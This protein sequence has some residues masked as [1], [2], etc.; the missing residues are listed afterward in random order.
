M[1][2]YGTYLKELWRN[3]KSGITRFLLK[4]TTVTGI[5]YIT[6]EGTIMNYPEG[7]PLLV[8][9]RYENIKEKSVFVGRA[10]AYSNSE[11][12]SIKFLMSSN[13]QDIGEVLAKKIVEIIGC[14]IFDNLTEEKIAEISKI[15]G[16]TMKKA[17]YVS[18]KL[19]KY[20]D[21]EMLLHYIN[22]EGGNF[23][24]V[25]K[26]YDKYGS[27]ALEVIKKNPYILLY[28]DASYTLCEQ[29]AYKLGI[30]EYDKKRIEAIVR[31]SIINNEKN[32]NT[33][34]SFTAL[35]KKVKFY[36]KRAGM[37]YKTNPLF[38][39]E[40]I[41]SD[42]YHIEE[43]D[44]EIHVA[45]EKTNISEDIIVS[46]I[47][48]LIGVSSIY[49]EERQYNLERIQ[50]KNGIIYNSEQREVI[51]N[52]TE[53][54][55]ICIITGGPGTG[56]T[57]ILKAIIDVFEEE[58]ENSQIL[59]CSPT[60]QAAQ[61]MR[62]AT[63][64]QANT[65]HKTLNMKPYEDIL[66]VSREKLNADVIIVDEFS[67]VDTELFSI[68]LTRIKNGSLLI[69]MGDEQQLQSVGP[70]NILGDLIKSGK[71]PV[72]K[73]KTICR[74]S[75]GDENIIV[76]NAT[77]VIEGN[78]DLKQSDKFK[79]KILK[80]EGLVI[81]EL[82][83]LLE[84]K[85]LSGEFEDTKIYTPIRHK[86][87]NLGSVQLN[88]KIKERFFKTEKGV[89]SGQYFFSEGDF[90]IFNKNNY[91]KGY[92]NG[93]EGEIISIQKHTETLHICIQMDGD[94]IDI[95]KSEL[96]DIELGYA[97]TAH[98][99]QGSECKTS[100]IIVPE[101]PS[102]MLQRK[103]LYVEITRAKEEVYILSQNDA[104]KKAISTLYEAKRVTGLRNKLIAL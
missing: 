84:E 69:L 7:I 68:L 52:S 5:K 11:E 88:K 49:N 40:E 23:L 32:G 39:A 70:G 42:K 46:E 102:S 89:Y 24:N 83:S 4:Q 50:E 56:K 96:G 35:C 75:G 86:K 101:R 64:K 13:F 48:R 31:H 97:A 73:L 8:D 1:K 45:F 55:G 25:T 104:L 33:I 58:H 99:A 71:I 91:E 2:I 85:M 93:A 38:V 47:R 6:C 61:K 62:D 98:K 103:I 18:R 82:N 54:S 30:K 57:T 3:E 12:Y 26:V 44:N 28:A 22:E 27:D 100:I 15:N 10:M 74:Q 20:R 80:T 16:F 19:K 90:V 87:F 60:G 95:G 72:Y 78:Q 65:I 66:S 14:N 43:Y 17:E 34:I 76:E 53:R 79:I 81:N 77:K 21:F 63:K 9:G 94:I 59:L 92:Y 37:G 29:I 51:H 67:M 41:L 36:E